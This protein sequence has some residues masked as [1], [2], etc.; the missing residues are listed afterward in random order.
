MLGG[1]G[2]AACGLMADQAASG[3][4]GVLCRPGIASW[5]VPDFAILAAMWAVM[6]L[7][8]TMPTAGP[9]ILTYAEIADTATRKREAVVSP[10][11]LALGN[12]MVWVGFAFV[13]ALLQAAVAHASIATDRIMQT[14]FAA[15]VFL[16][17]G[18]YQFS[19]L[20]AACLTLCHR[21]FPFFFANR[22]NRPGGVFALGARHGVYCL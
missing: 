13:P 20:K 3:W 17:G 15:A 10:L 5:D 19:R 7:A 16:V 8:M 11:V 9:M 4:L 2:W 18:I 1:L 21:P 6:T 14:S 12:V 22:T